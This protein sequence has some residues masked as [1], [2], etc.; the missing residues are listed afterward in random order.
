MKDLSESQG[1]LKTLFGKEK[2]EIVRR[3]FNI[4]DKSG[5]ITDEFEKIDVVQNYTPTG[6]EIIMRTCLACLIRGQCTPYAM[7][8]S[9]ICD[10]FNDPAI[11]QIII[12]KQTCDGCGNLG[13]NDPSFLLTDSDCMACRLFPDGEGPRSLHSENFSFYAQERSG[14]DIIHTFDGDRFDPFENPRVCSE[15]RQLD[16]KRMRG[17][18]EDKKRRNAEFAESMARQAR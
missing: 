2:P 8:H 18:V 10:R 3:V 9:F 16:L 5:K 11:L 7:S 4:L 17:W 13:K 1:I 15:C 6:Q 14:L 12:P